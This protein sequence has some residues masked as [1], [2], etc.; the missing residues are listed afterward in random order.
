M[1]GA[2]AVPVFFS[3]LT[4]RTNRLPE[5]RPSS[6]PERLLPASASPV[7]WS[8]PACRTG[9]YAGQARAGHSCPR[10]IPPTPGRT[11]RSDRSH[12]PRFPSVFRRLTRRAPRSAPLRA[13]LPKPSLSVSQY[14]VESA[15]RDPMVVDRKPHGESRS[16]GGNP[17]DGPMAEA[18]RPR[19]PHGTHAKGA[20]QIGATE[21]DG[22]EVQ[23]GH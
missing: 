13:A 21:N 8:H 15:E 17:G 22:I 2:T 23:A 9:R 16:S 18:V 6:V 20:S 1:D 19:P 4:M 5:E 11:R 14:H 10:Q 12:P 7:W 3:A